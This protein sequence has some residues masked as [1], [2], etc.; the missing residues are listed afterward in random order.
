LYGS[1]YSSRIFVSCVT[2]TL[3]GPWPMKM[4]FG[5][6]V[7]SGT[8]G[9]TATGTSGAAAPDELSSCASTSSASAP[10]HYTIGGNQ[11]TTTSTQ[12]FRLIGEGTAPD[13]YVRSLFHYTI[14]A[15]GVWRS[16]RSE[17]T[18]DCSHAHTA[19]PPSAA[20]CGDAWQTSGATDG[21]AF[22]NFQSCVTYVAGGGTLIPLLQAAIDY[23][24]ILDPRDPPNSACMHVTGFG[25]LAGSEVVVKEAYEGEPIIYRLLVAED[26][27]LDLAHGF[28]CAPGIEEIVV[29]L[30]ATATSAAGAALATPA[31]T[32]SIFC[33]RG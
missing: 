3:F 4:A 21:S 28:G 24:C 5:R 33:T 32:F 18:V 12:T 13:L 7:G 14:D 1:P 26:G 29:G 25:L 6:F 16:S 19:S 17:F 9:G 15:N 8:G 23:S 20:G 30:N 2:G 11:S 27:K 22:R 31:V 10:V